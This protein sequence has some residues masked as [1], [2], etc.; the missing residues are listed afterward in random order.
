MHHMR[1]RGPFRWAMMGVMFVLF[2][3]AA[4][5]VVSYVAMSLW[6]WLLPALFGFKTITY[7]QALG[8]LVLSWIFF[9]RF[10]GGHWHRHGH[11][12]RHRLHERMAGMSPEELKR[13]AEEMQD[14]HHRHPDQG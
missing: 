14:W 4:A 12:W 5:F 11:R 10:R 3:A 6:N 13:F 8:L 2:A 9:G 7:W 1:G